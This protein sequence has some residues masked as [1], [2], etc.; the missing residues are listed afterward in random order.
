MLV[1]YARVSKRNQDVQMQVVA[2][3]KYG[4][5]KIFEEKRSGKTTRRKEYQRAL[6]SLKP[7][8]TLVFWHIDRLGRNARELI[9]LEYDLRA[10]EIHI[11][12]LTQNLDTTTVDGRY[13]FQKA[14]A[15][16]EHESGKISLRTLGGLEMAALQGHY[17][18]RQKGLNAQQVKT[19]HRLYAK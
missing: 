4:C 3:R 2:L 19:V 9:N 18:G 10:R 15:D 12:S 17:P 14:C 16:A 11:V 6:A 8:D 5:K 1:G 13:H 7:G